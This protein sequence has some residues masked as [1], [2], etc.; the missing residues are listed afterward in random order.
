MSSAWAVCHPEA[1]RRHKYLPNIYTETERKREKERES[2]I[3]Y[4]IM[5]HNKTTNYGVQQTA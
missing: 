3:E 2:T 1:I 4:V 5:Y